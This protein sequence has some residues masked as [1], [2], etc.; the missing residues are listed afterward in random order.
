MYFFFLH[1]NEA[2][3]SDR[4]RLRL[5][6]DSL[7]ASVCD[8]LWSGVSLWALIKQLCFLFQG[9]L[10]SLW[11]RLRGPQ[12]PLDPQTKEDTHSLEPSVP[13]S[14]LHTHILTG[15]Y[16]LTA[17]FLWFIDSRLNGFTI[18]FN[19]SLSFSFLSLKLFL[20]S[21]SPLCSLFLFPFSSLH[22]WKVLFL[23]CLPSWLLSPSLLFILLT[24]FSAASSL[25][26]FRFVSLSCVIA[27]K[28]RE[29]CP[30]LSLSE[31]IVQHFDLRLFFWI[32]IINSSRWSGL[33]CL[34]VDHR[35]SRKQAAR[36]DITTTIV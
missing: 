5:I 31:F 20:V 6:R 10:F 16:G 11:I 28:D 2:V 14:L 29:K 26:S 1:E 24:F 23:H 33:K 4:R 30:P 27:V 25:F 3:R 12:R 17:G 7:G 34:S 13:I 19:M 35:S 15:H 32:K 9:W 8:V 22:A 36:H 18:F 21:F